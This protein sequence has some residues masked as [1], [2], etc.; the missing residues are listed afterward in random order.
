MLL[1][2]RVE[3]ALVNHVNDDVLDELMEIEGMRE[4]RRRL[5][6]AIPG[7]AD[8][9]AEH[10]AQLYSQVQK[11]L[12][13]ELGICQHLLVGEHDRVCGMTQCVTNC[14]IPAPRCAVLEEVANRQ[15]FMT[16]MATA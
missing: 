2:D 10:R 12:G 7:F 3:Q 11:G 13:I 6:K 1:K 4:R 9:P 5:I 16:A 15:L 8:W 14:L